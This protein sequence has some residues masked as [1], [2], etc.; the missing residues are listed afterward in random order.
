MFYFL[1]NIIY[2]LPQ[3]IRRNFL[4]A[5][6]RASI[7]A[8]KTNF[9]IC[10]PFR[11]PKTFFEILSPSKMSGGRK[12]WN[13]ALDL[14]VRSWLVCPVVQVRR[15]QKC[16][17]KWSKLQHNFYRCN[18]DRPLFYVRCRCNSVRL[19][20]YLI[21]FGYWLAMMNTVMTRSVKDP[22]Q[23]SQMIDNFSM[24]PE[25]IQKTKIKVQSL[26]IIF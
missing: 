4:N 1:K 25:L 17:P 18:I 2:I 10:W 21:Y 7:R 20:S 14:R 15:S 11:I 8:R 12:G 23:R 19:V 6:C 16:D 9:S 13:S 3:V 5:E 24:D 26:L 22:F